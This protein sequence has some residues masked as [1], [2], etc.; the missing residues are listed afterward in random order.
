MVFLRLV[1]SG[2]VLV[3]L[4]ACGGGGSPATPAPAPP[5]AGA[6]TPTPVSDAV[7]VQAPIS[8]N[9]GHPTFMSPHSKPIVINGRFVYAANTAGDT[10]DVI[11]SADRRA[12]QCRHRP[13][14]TCCAPG[15]DGSLG[16]QSRF[17]HGQRDRHRPSEPDASPCDRNGSGDRH[18]RLF[19]PS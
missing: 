19:N 17:G 4:V 6:P 9:A 15:R 12:N 10:V 14:R 8:T 11:D 3:L 7:G 18:L 16:G 5:P 2:L 13:R 1:C